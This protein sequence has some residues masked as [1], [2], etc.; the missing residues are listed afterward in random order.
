M[1]TK[2]EEFKVYYFSFDEDELSSVIAALRFHGDN[3]LADEISDEVWDVDKDE[4]SALSFDIDT[5]G[6]TDAIADL[7]MLTEAAEAATKATGDLYAV[8]GHE[9]STSKVDALIRDLI[10]GLRA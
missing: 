9:F 2:H 8:I 10:Q 4:T 3:A 5:S 6:V 1:P 7:K